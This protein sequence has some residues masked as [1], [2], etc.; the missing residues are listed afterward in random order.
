MGVII[1]LVFDVFEELYVYIVIFLLIGEGGELKFCEWLM[2]K[3][4]VL[5]FM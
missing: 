1:E 3:F 2:I 4:L 5:F